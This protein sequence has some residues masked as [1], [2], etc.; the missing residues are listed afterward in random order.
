[1]PLLQTKK[2][3]IALYTEMEDSDSSIE[4]SVIDDGMESVSSNS[5]DLSAESL[6]EDYD[7]SDSSD[8]S[9][10]SDVKL[11]WKVSDTLPNTR[12]AI[13]NVFTINKSSSNIGVEQIIEKTLLDI[14]TKKIPLLA[15]ISFVR[16]NN[17]K[18]ELFS[19]KLASLVPDDKKMIA[20]N[21]SGRVN[22][23]PLGVYFNS[24]E[25]NVYKVD[26][27]TGKNNFAFVQAE[28]ELAAIGTAIGANWNG[29]RAFTATSGPGISLM[30]EFI[31]LA[32]FAEIPLVIFDI[33]R[34]GPS[35]G[36]PTRTQQSDLLSCAYASHGDTKHIML[37]PC[38]PNECFNFAVDSF[39]IADR[40]QTPIF[41]LSDLDLINLPNTKM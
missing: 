32:Y 18:F 6:E 11:I 30:N 31:G 2:E 8:S 4:D 35:T 38:D 36:M 10:E 22:F 41:V 13:A 5:S 15:S 12:I 27:K 14:G 21:L 17:T 1:M 3:M 39:D 7:L 28:D 37:I 40:L 29:A 20:I 9:M 24:D 26:E 34:G 23:V 33:Q 25:S 16:L 19:N